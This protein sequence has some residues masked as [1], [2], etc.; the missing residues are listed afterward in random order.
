MV[1]LTEGKRTDDKFMRNVMWVLISSLI[2]VLISAGSGFVIMY[3]KVESNSV[4][5]GK[6]ATDYRT[7]LDIKV[8]V[9]ELVAN[10]RSREAKI[11]KQIRLQEEYAK[12]QQYIFGEQKW[13]KPVI[14]RA[15]RHFDDKDRHK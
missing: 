4:A 5:L 13:R 8:L 6:Y 12:T 10:S 3:G 9:A 7:M 1:K 15:I 14:D 11:D 2:T